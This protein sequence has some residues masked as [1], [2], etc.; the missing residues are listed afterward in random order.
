MSSLNYTH[1]TLSSSISQAEQLS[2][3]LLMLFD[4]PLDEAQLRA[5]IQPL[6]IQLNDD[7]Q[8]VSLIHRF[9]IERGGMGSPHAKRT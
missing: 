6:L 8:G 5:H 4:Q 1:E 2:L 3:A 9:M 7:L